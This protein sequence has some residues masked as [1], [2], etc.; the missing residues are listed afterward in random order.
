M[1]ATHAL[2]PTQGSRV[3]L[4]FTAQALLKFVL[5]G[6]PVVPSYGRAGTWATKGP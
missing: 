1:R 5:F 6:H 2:L 3:L 4:K